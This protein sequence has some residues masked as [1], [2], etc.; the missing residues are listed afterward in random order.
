MDVG[1]GGHTTYNSDEYFFR[2]MDCEGGRPT[3]IKTRYGF[4]NLFTSMV[5]TLA[6]IYIISI[7]EY[8][9]NIN[10]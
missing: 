2:L 5:Y 10:N 7:R 1:A 6:I 3:T 8:D 9:Y 4:K